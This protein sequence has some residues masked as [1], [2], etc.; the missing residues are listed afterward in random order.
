M[1][2]APRRGRPPIGDQAATE[3]IEIRL[4][5]RELAEIDKRA[6]AAGLS[7]SA[8]LVVA[9][10]FAGDPQTGVELRKYKAEAAAWRGEVAALQMQVD[11]M[12]RTVEGE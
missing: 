12:R 7:R 4:T 9:G 5:E 2:T 3:R 10:Q 8:Y 6:L 1:T 11:K